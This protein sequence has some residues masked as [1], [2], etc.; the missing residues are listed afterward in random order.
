MAY[1]RRLWAKDCYR[2]WSTD[3]L[4]YQPTPY[5]CTMPFNKITQ[6][7]I[8]FFHAI[9]GEKYV[10]ADVDNIDRCASDQTEDLHYPPEVVLQPGTTDEVSRI[11]KHCNDQMIP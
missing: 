10:L 9:V 3:L 4:P 7:H 5:L 6:A 8:S 1:F 11:M 2:P